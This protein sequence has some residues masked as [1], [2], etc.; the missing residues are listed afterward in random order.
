MAVH[1][2]LALCGRIRALRERSEMTQSTVAKFLGISQAAYCRLERGE[3][4]VSL[5]RLMKL[6][7][8]FGISLNQLM[9]GL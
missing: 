7:E 4:E 6:S 2:Q 1:R 8:L 3:I 9:D 5:S